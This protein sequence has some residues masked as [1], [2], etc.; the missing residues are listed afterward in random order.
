MLCENEKEYR[1]LVC[2]DYWRAWDGD[3]RN[4]P[5]FHSIRPHEAIHDAKKISTAQLDPIHH[6][7]KLSVID[8]LNLHFSW[9]LSGIFTINPSGTGLL[10]V[11]FP[12]VWLRRKITLHNHKARKV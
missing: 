10:R 12:Y 7:Q 11:N 8:V 4:K 3:V 6:P 9:H 5:S 1:V 2:I